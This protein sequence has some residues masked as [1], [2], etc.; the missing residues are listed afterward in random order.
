MVHYDVG[1]ISSHIKRPSN[2]EESGASTT[3]DCWRRRL[4]S[5]EQ[6]DL[7]SFLETLQQSLEALNQDSGKE[8]GSS[9]GLDILE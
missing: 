8:S 9:D 4:T 2:S 5:R 3:L 1:V 7:Q 6:D